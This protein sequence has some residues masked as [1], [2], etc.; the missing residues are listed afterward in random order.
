MAGL[1]AVFAISRPVA[2]GWL[3][4]SDFDWRLGER[5]Q[6]FRL[7]GVRCVVEVTGRPE[8]NHA[9]QREVAAAHPGTP[10]QLSVRHDHPIVAGTAVVEDIRVIEIGR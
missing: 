10:I 5:P 7:S 2:G 1:L 9:D 6:S 3:E 8:A 4:W